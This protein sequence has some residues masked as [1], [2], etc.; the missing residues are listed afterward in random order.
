MPNALPAPGH[1]AS[2]VDSLRAVSPLTAVSQ[3]LLRLEQLRPANANGRDRS[4][5]Y[6]SRKPNRGAR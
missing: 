3:A 2:Y 6:A 5:R 4:Q 1:L